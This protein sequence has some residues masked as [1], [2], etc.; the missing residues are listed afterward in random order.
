MNGQYEAASRIRAFSAAADQLLDFWFRLEPDD[1]LHQVLT[2]HYPSKALALSFDEV[3]AEIA[4]WA[5][6]VAHSEGRTLT[7]VHGP[8]TGRAIVSKHSRGQWSYRLVDGRTGFS[9]TAGGAL[10]LRYHYD[11]SNLPD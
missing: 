11:G 1:P 10:G 8:P 2:A 4:E 7:E 6:R 3:A 9:N 5:E